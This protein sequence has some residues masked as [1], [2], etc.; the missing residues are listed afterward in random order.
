M[1]GCKEGDIR[2]SRR[3]QCK[4]QERGG[5]NKAGQPAAA[6]S[7]GGRGRPPATAASVRLCWGSA[8]RCARST[9]M[10]DTVGQFNLNKE[11]KDIHT[12]V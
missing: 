2:I 7:H 9:C 8:I 11:F 4:R 10:Y 3:R 6:I 5:L 12:P 1:R